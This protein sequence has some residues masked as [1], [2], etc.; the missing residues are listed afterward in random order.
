MTPSAGDLVIAAQTLW[1][2]ARGETFE[3]KVAV[4]HVL[5]NRQTQAAA[6]KQRTGKTHPLF[7]DGTLA[8]VCLVPLQFSCRNPGDPNKDKLE[9]LSLPD[10]LTDRS[11]RDCLSALLQAV[12]G[13]AGD[14]TLGSLHYH[15]LGVAPAWSHGKVPV[16]QI[17]QHVFFNDIA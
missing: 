8:A 9:A 3:G 10:S 15:T 4:A 11:F 1:G 7:G 6:L 17:G 14:P 12:D 5:L 13:R 16:A 2:E